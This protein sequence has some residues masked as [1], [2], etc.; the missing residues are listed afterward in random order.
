MKWGP[1]TPSPRFEIKGTS[2]PSCRRADVGEE[3]FR[4]A[5][6]LGSHRLARVS[7]LYRKAGIQ[8]TAHASHFAHVARKHTTLPCHRMG[9]PAEQWSGL[10]LFSR[11]GGR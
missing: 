4:R 9:C 7:K 3:T 10:D 8:V 5:P 1:S 6:G 2:S 11:Q